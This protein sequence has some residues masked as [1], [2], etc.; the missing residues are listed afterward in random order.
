MEEERSILLQGYQ[1]NHQS[2]ACASGRRCSFSA[3][4]YTSLLHTILCLF[5]L[6][7]VHISSH[8]P[9]TLRLIVIIILARH[10]RSPGC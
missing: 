4:R 1:I 7:M 5:S 9:S 3:P 2:G 8:T 10:S 6:H